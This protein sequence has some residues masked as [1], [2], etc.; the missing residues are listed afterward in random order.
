MPSIGLSR[1]ELSHEPT[2]LG[3]FTQDLFKLSIW[4]ELDVPVRSPGTSPNEGTSVLIQGT[5]PGENG[6]ALI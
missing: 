5:L 3:V 6:M 1:V 2:P 4:L